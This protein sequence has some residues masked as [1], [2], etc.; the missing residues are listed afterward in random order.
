MARPK[1]SNREIYHSL[2]I[3]SKF[4]D[5]TP[6]FCTKLFTLP[7]FRHLKLPSESTLDRWCK[8]LKY[9]RSSQQQ[10][11]LDLFADH[12][13][14]LEKEWLYFNSPKFRRYQIKAID[15]WVSNNQ[16]GI[17]NLPTGSGKTAICTAIW[18]ELISN[19][20]SKN[21]TE[22]LIHETE[23]EFTQQELD[24][25]EAEYESMEEQ[26][27]YY[28]SLSDEE[29]KKLD[30]NKSEYEIYYSSL[31]DEERKKHDLETGADEYYRK[32]DEFYER[33][34]KVEKNVD[35]NYKG[36]L[37][38]IVCDNSNTNEMWNDILEERKLRYQLR[39]MDHFNH[40]IYAAREIIENIKNSNDE[41]YMIID[42]SILSSKE[43]LNEINKDLP[44]LLIVDQIEE[45]D[46]QNFKIDELS[47]IE[48]R[49]G[50]INTSYDSI[51]ESFKSYFNGLC[52]EMNIK[53]LI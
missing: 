16:K 52:F 6:E 51:D 17:M 43:F 2:E 8:K 14:L 15:S 5:I 35:A 26:E 42:S 53:E 10:R 12:P 50:L 48:N 18:T 49:L 29:R 41:G 19:I 3:A 40:T 46:N 36:L 11:M 44:V 20:T 9:S 25:Q 38:I 27:I 34:Y 31:S 37:V 23:L 30:D 1:K 47:F 39:D 32:M 7:Q 21:W 45:I 22:T 24:E 33:E 4:T 13:S 28:S